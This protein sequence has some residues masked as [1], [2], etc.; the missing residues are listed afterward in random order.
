MTIRIAV[1]LLVALL[2]A[3]GGGEGGD[4]GTPSGGGAGC[5][6]GC[7]IAAP[8]AL[9]VVEGQQVIRQAVQELAARGRLG[10]VA[11]VDRVG[12]VLAVFR[13]TGASTTVTITSGRGVTGGL[14]NVPII[15]D[16]AAA[17]AKAVTGA[18]LSSEGN[19]FT[20]RTAS[21]IVQENFN[22]GEINSPS[23]P[24]FGVQF[25]SLSCSD[26]NQMSA[27]GTVGPKPTPLGL[28]ADPG[29]LPLYKAGTVVGGVGVIADATYGLDLNIFDVDTSV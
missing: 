13:M 20:T 8:Q 23:G 14:E 2:A 26:V 28:S 11:V 3:C 21:Q 18:Y 29:G 16:A 5:T 9:T 10:T 15:P 22:P 24:L 27:T 4:G 19:A 7:G 17:I 1:C 12:N 6:G 25:S